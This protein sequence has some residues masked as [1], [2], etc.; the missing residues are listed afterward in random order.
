M[1][2]KLMMVSPR[3]WPV[4]PPWRRLAERRGSSFCGTGGRGRLRRRRLGLRGFCRGGTCGFGSLAL[5]GELVGE[6]LAGGDELA[7]RTVFALGEF[8]I[9]FAALAVSEIGRVSPAS[10]LCAAP[11][12][13]RGI[14]VRVTVWSG[15]ATRSKPSE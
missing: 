5:L 8:G 15:P 14:T 12:C 6:R 10:S 1:L 2:G 4:R 3:G 13:L 11:S 9:D 7:E